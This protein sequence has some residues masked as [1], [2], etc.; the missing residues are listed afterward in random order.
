[1]VRLPSAVLERAIVKE[2][3]SSS[4]LGSQS[5]AP[6]DWPQARRALDTAKTDVR[7][8][9]ADASR[10]AKSAQEGLVLTEAQL[11]ALEKA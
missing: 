10:E 3:K 7:A 1:M 9:T 2:P 6:H 5:P 8:K 11:I 4:S